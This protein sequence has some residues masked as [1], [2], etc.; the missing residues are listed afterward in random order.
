[1]KTLYDTVICILVKLFYPLLFVCLGLLVYSKGLFTDFVWDDQK[2]IVET[3]FLHS[4][5]FIPIFFVSSIKDVTREGKFLDFYYKPLLFSTYSILY[6]LGN[7]APFAFHLFQIFLHAINSLFLYYLFKRFLKQNLALVLALVF[8]VHPANQEAVVYIASLQDTLFFFFGIIALLLL[9]Y[10]PFRELNR[11]RLVSL[12]LLFSLLSKETGVLFVAISILYLVFFEK[13]Q[14]A[15]ASIFFI[16]PLV[17]YSVLRIRASDLHFFE[18]KRSEVMGMSLAERITIIPKLIQ[19]YLK[20][21]FI[22]SETIIYPATKLTAKI[23]HTQGLILLL[24]IFALSFTIIKTVW[25]SKYFYPTLFFLIWFLAG[26]GIHLQI[27]PL[28]TLVAKR[29]LYFPLAGMLG[30]IGII[31]TKLDIRKLGNY[32]LFSFF[33]L[34]IGFFAIQTFR[35]NSYWKDVGKLN[36]DTFNLP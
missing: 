5:V 12:F 13:R 36:T 14:L 6:T 28:D 34:L 4:P 32:L 33:I 16:F 21:I 35:M 10:K 11:L 19:F 9:V 25:R 7:G 8:L 17:L 18:I 29:W 24:G 15:K 30:F 26:I 3:S 20:E 1:M 27:F 22:P 23:P 2:Q 31:I